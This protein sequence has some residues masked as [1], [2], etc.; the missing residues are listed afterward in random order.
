M[1]N[2]IDYLQTKSLA[3][4]CESCL[5]APDPN[6]L[7]DI[8]QFLQ[9]SNLSQKF[10]QS[11]YN[12]LIFTIQMILAEIPKS[13]KNSK[14]SADQLFRKCLE[15]YQILFQKVS[16]K[17]SKIF[18]TIFKMFSLLIDRQS[19]NQRN[20]DSKIIH[21]SDNSTK[22]LID[23][24]IQLLSTC[25]QSM[26]RDF[27]FNQTGTVQFE[28]MY[29]MLTNNLLQIIIENDYQPLKTASLD[30]MS[31]MYLKIIDK[32][33]SDFNYNSLNSNQKNDEKFER[34]S[35]F[36]ASILPG[37][38]SKIWKLLNRCSNG[39]YH[40]LQSNVIIAALRL[41]NIVF[42]IVFE[43]IGKFTEELL[44][45]EKFYRN[46]STIISD[47]IDI[48]IE[49][50]DL[51][52]RLNL[53]KFSKSLLFNCDDEKFVQK[54]IDNLIKIPLNYIGSISINEQQDEHRNE[55]N[56]LC[57]NFS[58]KILEKLNMIEILQKKLFDHLTQ[59]PY[60]FR[61][62]H[63]HNSNR[64]VTKTCLKSSFQILIGFIHTLNRTGIYDFLKL[65]QHN[66]HLFRT[67][68]NLSEFDFKHSKYAVYE[69]VDD[70]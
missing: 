20:N 59:M 32:Q 35:K 24:T 15:I 31:T 8:K 23:C 53:L 48:L 3:I 40:N 69:D 62:I 55:M 26:F 45:D 47:I 11:N 39:D 44:N 6:K 22:L 12:R 29:G 10:F 51:N 41:L 38:L 37:L 25:N 67:L 7:D 52:V 4:K 61:N 2:N 64:I 28:T 46:L 18:D 19:S 42:L 16:I 1:A 50:T 5:F 49:H 36:I 21:L 30:L 14:F 43:N 9:N 57:K 68:I 54:Q 17:D 70:S 60:T 34:F 66:H 63:N 33:L 56:D 27:I 58:A 65:E 13:V